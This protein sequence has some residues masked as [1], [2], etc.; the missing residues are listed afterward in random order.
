MFDVDQIDLVSTIDLDLV[1]TRYSVGTS[2]ALTFQ[3]DK[4]EKEKVGQPSSWSDLRNCYK[5]TTNKI[6]K[7]DR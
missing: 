5:T 7:I 2:V 3:A 6:K 1:A 4:K